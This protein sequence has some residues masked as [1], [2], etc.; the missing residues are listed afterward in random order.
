MTECIDTIEAVFRQQGAGKA[1]DAAVIGAH[2][3][4]GG[5]HI[6]TAGLRGNS[7]ERAVF[8]T[9]VNANFPGNPSRNGLP[10]IQGVVLLFDADVGVPLAIL[11]SIEITSVRTAAATA[12]AARYLAR[13][14]ASTVTVCGCGEQGRSQLRALLR[15]RPVQRVF[16]FDV[17]FPKAEQY[18]IE[19]R[20]E[21]A[22]EVVPVQELG[23]ITRQADIWVT[24]TPAQHWF[25]GRDHVAPGAFIAAVGADNPTKQE[26]APDLLAAS[27]VVA[28]VL[29]QCV[30]MGDLHHA[31]ALGAMTRDD[32]HAELTDVVMG[33]RPGRRTDDEIIVFD[34]TG[35]ALEDVAAA[36]LVYDRAV[37]TGMGL[38]IDLGSAT[39]APNVN[40]AIRQ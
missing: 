39:A 40:R 2:V 15:V 18:A 9:K 36:K 10:T 35:T 8:V 7:V 38:E 25:V 16:A 19:M 5:F 21:L 17:E 31:I 11:D 23:A 13:E 37:A 4:G 29:D 14:D 26:I 32:V 20:E 3:E 27:T 34:S 1:I 22:I 12:V 33:R 6:K 24:C 28:D 30:V